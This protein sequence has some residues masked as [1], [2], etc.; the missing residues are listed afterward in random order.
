MLGHRS[1]EPGVSGVGALRVLMANT[2]GQAPYKTEARSPLVSRL[3]GD[4][5][6]HLCSTRS[7][8]LSFFATGLRAR[9]YSL[10]K[11]RVPKG[12]YMDSPLQI[13][14]GFSVGQ[15]GTNLRTDVRTV[16]ILLQMNRLRFTSNHSCAVDGHM[17]QSLKDLLGDFQ[18]QI[19]KQL[20]EPSK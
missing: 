8:S 7:R 17:T 18:T 1:L 2:G 10:H 14:I 6:H 13:C 4:P 9:R 15:G 16:Q 3:G 11:K 5:D 12:S 20:P 19:V